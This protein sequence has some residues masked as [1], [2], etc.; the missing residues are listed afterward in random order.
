MQPAEQPGRKQVQIRPNGDDR[1]I[2]Y[3]VENRR[4]IEVNAVGARLLELQL[5]QGLGLET[6]VA[7]VSKEFGV[8]A[9][10]VRADAKTFFIAIEER[11]TSTVPDVLDHMIYDAPLT[12][13]LQV[14]EACNLRCRHCFQREYR[15]Q[16]CLPIDLA[17][18]IVH[19]LAD[20]QVF[21]L[22]VIGGE[23]LLYSG[24]RELLGRCS[25][26]GI[27]TT[28]VTNATMVDSQSAA[29]FRCNRT[30]VNVSVDGIG[31][32]HDQIRGVGT[33]VRVDKAVRL[34]RCVGVPVSLLCT[35]NLLNADRYED[36]IGYAHELGVSASFNLFKPTKSEHSDLVLSPGRYFEICLELFARQQAG[37]LIGLSNAA[38]ANL[39]A[40]G[41][42]RNECT[43]TLAGLVID[44]AGRMVSCPGLVSCGYLAESALPAFDE[45]WLETW[46]NHPIF[47]DFREHGMR[48]CQVRSFIFTGDLESPDPY[49]ATA[50]R[51]YQ[52]GS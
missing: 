3:F 5:N 27:A 4:M 21:E 36:V 26:L 25:E 29:M 17:L 15:A 51:S 8:G 18:R 12:V 49:S 22:S 50:L 48:G 24:L 9:D 39:L 13:E 52:Q 31:S 19:A 14:N 6:V 46:H 30:H 45:N 10:G 38:I 40:G 11:L 33:F 43:A 37:E 34:L 32:T 41:D 7:E 42:E 1:F 44:Y 23:P 47:Q 16:S 35:L 28:V 2:A 20:A